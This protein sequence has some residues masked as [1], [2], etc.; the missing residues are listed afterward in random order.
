[1]SAVFTGLYA[2]L[3][4]VLAPIS[5]GPVQ[6]R[7]ADCLVPLAALF[8]WPVVVGVT[9][10]CFLGNAYW[11][12]GSLDVALGPVANFIAASLVLLLRKKRLLACVV[13]A[14]PIGVIVGGYLW[15]FFPPP[16]IFGL[17]LPAWAAM[18]V[19]ITI[20][21]LIAMAVIGYGLLAALSRPSVM[22]ALRAKGLKVVAETE[23]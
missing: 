4:V 19:S 16:S 12:L 3:V 11:W 23:T 5:F 20:S 8:G 17:S 1:L 13:G 7:L 2:V 6:L 22:E 18:M 10:G 9:A 21:S 15:L 14:F